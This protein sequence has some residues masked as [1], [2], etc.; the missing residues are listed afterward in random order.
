[1]NSSGSTGAHSGVANIASAAA[2]G[3]SK[4]FINASADG[5]YGPSGTEKHQR[6]PSLRQR[7][8]SG[9]G[10]PPR[11][12]AVA[13]GARP[14]GRAG[15]S[16]NSACNVGPV[17]LAAGRRNNAPRQYPPACAVAISAGARATFHCSRVAMLP[18]NQNE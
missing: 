1:M 11:P 3:N 9:Q 2:R 5:G 18:G 17:K 6:A 7:T 12:G 4:H 15:T 16:A 14:P 10:M 8:P 13:S